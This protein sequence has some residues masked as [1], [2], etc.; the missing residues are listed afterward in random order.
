MVLL[1]VCTISLLKFGI[2][3]KMLWTSE[4][5]KQLE[6][7][8]EIQ[9][10]EEVQCLIDRLS[11]TIEL[12]TAEYQLPDYVSNIRKITWKGFELE[13]LG[14]IEYP[15]WIYTLDE[16]TG[17][18]FNAEAFTDA[19]FIGD[20]IH[21]GTPQGKPTSYFYSA[22]GENKIVFNPSPNENLA[23]LTGDIWN[24]NLDQGV[25]IEFYRTPNGNDWTLPK[26][27]RRRTIKAYVLWKAFAR[28]GDG[29]NLRASEYWLQKYQILIVRAQRIIN[30]INSAAIYTRSDVV[31]NRT[32]ARPKLPPNWDVVTVDEYGCEY[33]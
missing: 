30:Q 6:L 2:A 24:N 17:G 33:E 21:S 31:Q 8:A 22:F 28:E 7:E 3:N 27:I 12:G 32:I 9:I 16:V 25:V 1:I 13:P 20:S 18:A 23:I 26:Y 29:Q 11:L 19:F 5:L 15:N 10:A 4:Y 14:H